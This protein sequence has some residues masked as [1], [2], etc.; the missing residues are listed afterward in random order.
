M[1]TDAEV[2]L[3]ML[4][5]YLEVRKWISQKSQSWFIIMV[6]NLS[7]IL[8]DSKDSLVSG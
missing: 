1:R 5:F 2:L 3:S 7:E 4:E 8:L 6:R